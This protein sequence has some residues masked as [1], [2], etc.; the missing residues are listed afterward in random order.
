MTKATNC[1]SLFIIVLLSFAAR[2]SA[3]YTTRITHESTIILPPDYNPYLSYPVVVMLPFTN[4]DAE[5]MFNAY[6]AEAESDAETFSEK[7]AD[8]L[9][10]FNA[11][12]PESPQSFVVILPKGK[13]SR[14]DHSWRGFEQCFTRYEERI[15]KDVRK[16]A[17]TYS[18]DT[19]RVYLTGVS[20]GGDLAWAIS[21]RNPEFFQGALVMGSRCSYPP[22]TGTLELMKSKNYAFFMTMGMK[23]A[24]DRL[25]GMRY[26]RKQL[27]SLQILSIY[28]E[29][30]D[31]Y[32][33]KAP[34][35][36]FVE[37]LE[38]LLK[39]KKEI[40]TETK[41]RDVW[42]SRVVG[43][44]T[45]DLELSY[46][47]L[48]VE[49]NDI[50]SEGDGLYVPYKT[51]FVEGVVLEIKKLSATRVLLQL[52]FDNLFP[53][54]AYI[55]E[56]TEESETLD[57]SIYEQES[58]GYKCR[59]SAI[60]EDDSRVHGLM[61]MELDDANL[62]ISFDVFKS[63]EPDRYKTYNFFVRLE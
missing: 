58:K 3:Q 45:G 44:F 24:K 56:R 13:G 19:G 63:N 18:L 29:M 36:L 61:R 25:A 31:L 22:P 43:S 51:E 57:F 11:R 47:D 50:L 2:L 41:V 59:G 53:V 54:E 6:S 48:D 28:K 8:I 23:E 62:S 7:L 4:G 40:V 16:F 10:V 35:W 38:Y 33:H 20:L 39:Q 15:L 1:I 26:A 9:T 27:D 12:N 34:L 46:Y 42:I 37:G 14:R 49:K 17:K 32:H 5:Y 52:H 60:G 21:Q 55:S 30:P